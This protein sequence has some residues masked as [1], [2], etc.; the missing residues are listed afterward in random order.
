MNDWGTVIQTLNRVPGAIAWALFVVAAFMLHLRRPGPATV[1]QIGGGIVAF[2]ALCVLI[3]GSTLMQTQIG[4]S[5]GISS[6]R[7]WA[8]LLSGVSLVY[9]GGALVYAIAL[10]ATLHGLPRRDPD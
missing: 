5:G 9:Q 3:L 2:A 6:A 1:A 8:P 7:T 4:Q 10:I